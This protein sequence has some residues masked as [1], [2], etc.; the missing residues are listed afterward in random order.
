LQHLLLEGLDD[1]LL[2]PVVAQLDDVRNDV[3]SV[4]VLGEVEGALEALFKQ[5]S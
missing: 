2:V 1:D 5:R 4:L 3:V